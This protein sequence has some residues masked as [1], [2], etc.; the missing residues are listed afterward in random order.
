M[1]DVPG[2]VDLTEMARRLLKWYRQ[3]R[4]QLPWRGTSKQPAD[5]YHV[6]VSEAMLQQTQV[7]TV[8]DYFQRFIKTF[9]TLVSLAKADEQQVLHLWQGL[10]YYRRARHLHAAAKAIVE[11]HDGQLPDDVA[12]LRQLPGVGAYTAGAIASIAFNQPTPLIDGNVARVLARLFHIEQ[13]V[14][15]PAVQKKLWQLADDWV[16]AAD[17]YEPKC[18]GDFNQSLMELGA[19][20]CTPQQ[21]RCLVCPL[22]ENCLANQ[23][24]D[25]ERL[26]I[27]RPKKKPTVVHHHVLLIRRRGKWLVCQRPERGLW[28]AMWELTTFENPKRQTTAELKKLL[29]QTHGLQ[30]SSLHQV[31]RF[32]HQ[33]THRSITFVVHRATEL[34]GRCKAGAQWRTLDQLQNHPMSNPQRKVLAWLKAEN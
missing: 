5:A 33:T 3:E 6:L 29:H 27:K 34:T 15:D 13:P 24:S 2:N 32:D 9:P 10:G 25:A 1:P 7:A 28:S 19:L 31:M 26:P 11:K 14:D 20:I 4:R 8:I 23:Q 18:A 16:S 22:R 30:C 12:S 17:Q 21:P